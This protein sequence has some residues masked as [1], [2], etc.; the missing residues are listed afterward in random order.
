VELGQLVPHPKHR[1][2][3]QVWPLAQANAAPQPPQLL[4]SVC[5]S[6]QL[7]PHGVGVVEGHPE[8]HA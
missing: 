4:T 6:T 7:P 2:L 5:T 8:P 3:L 1:P